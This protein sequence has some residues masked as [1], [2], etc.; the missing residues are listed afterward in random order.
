MGEVS[1]RYFM[2]CEFIEDGKTI[3][4][5]SIG[6]VAED[7]RELYAE[8]LEADF[9]KANDWVR[10][11]VLAHLWSRQPSKREANAWSRDGGTGGLLKRADIAREVVRF[12]DPQLYGKPE[13]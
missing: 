1:V 7:G 2:D 5:V 13:I 11:N 6:I 8:S 12:C 3:D 9:S 10:E 4:L